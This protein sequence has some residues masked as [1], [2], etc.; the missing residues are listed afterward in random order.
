MSGHRGTYIASAA[1]LNRIESLVGPVCSRDDGAPSPVVGE[2]S[3]IERSEIEPG[4]GS[5]SAFANTDRDPSSAFDAS[6]LR[7]PLPQGERGKS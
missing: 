1:H 3:E 7:H 2:G 4:E 5:V 6:H